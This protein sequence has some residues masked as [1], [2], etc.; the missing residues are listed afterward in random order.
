[1]AI[2]QDYDDP[3]EAGQCTLLGGVLAQINRPKSGS[4]AEEWAFI[5]GSVGD[6]KAFLW[7]KETKEVIDLTYDGD[8]GRLNVTDSGGRLGPTTVT[9]KPDLRNLKISYVEC[10]AGDMIVIGSDGF[11]DNFDA[12][13]LGK[14]PVDL[15]WSDVTW[16]GMDPSDTALLKNLYRCWYL[17]HKIFTLSQVCP[18]TPALVV[19]RVI[20][21]CYQTTLKSREFMEIYEGKKLPEN[22]LEY[23][24][25]MDHT[26]CVCVE[27]GKLPRPS[28]LK[29]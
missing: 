23:P 10:H 22:Y 14:L 12:Q 25:K 2:L 17:K 4:N 8:E 29:R 26:S 6:C 20:R 3:E 24:G 13:S 5:F 19:N 7:R 16:E 11:H 9:C 21:H 15:G 18:P 28:A 27:V 1:M